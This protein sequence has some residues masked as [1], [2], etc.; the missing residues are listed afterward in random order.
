MRAWI[1]ESK[2]RTS[3]YEWGFDGRC[4]VWTCCVERGD[5]GAG[6]FGWELVVVKKELD[7]RAHT[8]LGVGLS[9]QE[10]GV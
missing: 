10:A 1:R 9:I 2:P 7:E 8:G 6:G 5:C 4:A 3:G